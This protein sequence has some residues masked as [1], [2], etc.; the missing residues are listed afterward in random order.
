MHAKLDGMRLFHVDAFTRTRFTGNPACVVLDADHG[1]DARLAALAREYPHAEVVFVLAATAPDHDCVLRFFN[2]RKEMP[3]VGHATI[4]AHAVLYTIGRRGPG[5]LRQRSGTGIIAVSAR[6]EPRGS[7][8][9]TIEFRQGLPEL[10]APLAEAACARVAAALGV[11]K[12]ALHNALPPTIARKG[13][14]R[15]LLPVASAEVLDA[16]APDFDALMALGTELGAE[17]FF[18]FTQAPGARDA[19]GDPDRGGA[20]GALWAATESRMF[21]PALGIDE[22]P[23]SGN[24]HAMLA[25]YLWHH[26]RLDASVWGFRGRQGR[27]MGRPGEV[28]VSLDVAGGELL[29]ARIAGQAI[30]V[31]IEDPAAGSAARDART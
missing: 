15:L 11:P 9:P 14:T 10:S 8:A 20:L 26:G 1:D 27:R 13:S 21:C 5:V 17:G 31:S 16:L 30:I 25:A 6:A 2:S 19:P 23:V 24:A 28:R 29:A 3:F 7:V 12:K 18:A 22:D 4:A